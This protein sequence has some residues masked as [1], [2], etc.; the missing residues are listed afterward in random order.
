MIAPANTLLDRMVVRAAG[1]DGTVEPP[2][3]NPFEPVEDDVEVSAPKVAKPAPATANYKAQEPP[4]LALQPE[5]VR[6]MK[7]ETERP[8]PEIC[9]RVVTRTI[10][11]PRMERRSVVQRVRE[12]YAI[13]QIVAL[14]G[15]DRIIKF[16]AEPQVVREASHV[17]ERTA[18]P[19]AIQ[20]DLKP[21]VLTRPE[22][23][24]SPADSR[25]ITVNVT[26]GR[27]EIKKAPEKGGAAKAAKPRND[28]SSLQQFLSKRRGFHE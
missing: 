4:R 2:L 20:P 27:L 16:P 24:S 22:P 8:A 9:E 23:R 18:T 21:E 10:A 3:A 7:K 19:E 11:Q 1:Q 28:E 5:A 13:D 26:I 6:A 14:P 15:Q 25:D 17:P 12:P